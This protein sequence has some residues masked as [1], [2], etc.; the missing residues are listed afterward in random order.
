MMTVTPKIA[1]KS[2]G[3]DEKLEFFDKLIKSHLERAREL[4][5][6]VAFTGFKGSANILTS[7]GKR[8]EIPGVSSIQEAKVNGYITSGEEY[9]VRIY[10][11]GLCDYFEITTKAKESIESIPL[12]LRTRYK[13]DDEEK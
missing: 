4:G 5:R 13:Y 2:V 9:S 11:D 7:D 10:P 3:T 1:Q 6:P 8:E 12:L